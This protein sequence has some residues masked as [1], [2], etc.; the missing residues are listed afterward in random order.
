MKPCNQGPKCAVCFP[1][2]C[3]K[4]LYKERKRLEYLCKMQLYICRPVAAGGACEGGS[5]E[6]YWLLVALGEAG[7]VPLKPRRGALCQLHVPHSQADH[8]SRASSDAAQSAM[9]RTPARGLLLLF[10]L[11]AL[12]SLAET[13][14]SLT[15][16]GA[17]GMLGQPLPRGCSRE[18]LSAPGWCLCPKG[19]GNPGEAAPF[20]AF[21]T[22]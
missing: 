11:L 13:C 20:G 22:S 16:P 7:L 15:L 17:R 5:L 14:S 4:K 9:V 8:F 3:K 21:L 2:L 18:W 19:E 10:L 1:E 6:C 12:R